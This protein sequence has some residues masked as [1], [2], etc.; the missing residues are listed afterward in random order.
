MPLLRFAAESDLVKLLNLG[1]VVRAEE[2]GLRGLECDRN[3]FPGR[4]LSLKNPVKL[5]RER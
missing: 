5:W 1:D 3:E 4:V 2:R